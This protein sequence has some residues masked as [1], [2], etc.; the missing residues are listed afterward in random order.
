ME[1]AVSEMW[2]GGQRY[3]TGILRDITTRKQV[4]TERAQLYVVLQDK[5]TELERARLFG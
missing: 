5:N 2:L 3:F 4:E 1:M